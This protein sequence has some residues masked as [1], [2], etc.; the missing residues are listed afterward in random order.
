MRNGSRVVVE[1][2][3]EWQYSRRERK[4]KTRSVYKVG[5]T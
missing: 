3:D 2:D 1:G 4:G 5:T